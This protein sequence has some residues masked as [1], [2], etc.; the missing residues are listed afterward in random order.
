MGAFIGFLSALA[1]AAGAPDYAALHGRLMEGEG[2]A[3]LEDALP[4]LARNLETARAVSAAEW[5]DSLLRDERAGADIL[6]P[7][8]LAGLG[9]RV[10]VTSGVAHVPAGV[11]HTYGY[12]F[13]RLE[14]P[15]GLKSRRWLWSR[16]DERLGLPA[17]TFSPTPPEG[18]FTGNVTRALRRLVGRPG[19]GRVEETVTWLAA[20][21]RVTWTVRT[22]LHPLAAYPGREAE[23]HLLVYAVETEGVRRF[24]TAFPVDPAFAARLMATPPGSGATFTPRYNLFVDPAWRVVSWSSRGWVR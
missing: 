4:G 8:V 5:T 10:S 13:S 15:Y 16:L 3:A 17:G 1:F 11:M 23:S 7:R 19:A 9:I 14:T 12:L 20:G 24:V 18:E 2:A 22:Y 21:R 6:P